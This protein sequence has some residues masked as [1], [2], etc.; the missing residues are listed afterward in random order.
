MT[1]IRTALNLTFNFKIQYSEFRIQNLS[2][3]MERLI[4]FVERFKEYFTF[5]ALVIVSLALIA[6][7]DLSKIG[8]F[9]TIVIG[10]VGWMQNVFS[11]IPN[12]GELRNE[13]RTL[14]EM[15]LQLSS[16]VVKMRHALLENKSLR[17][18]LS[19]NQKR[20]YE[21]ISSDVI[22]KNL[23][24]MRNYITLDKGTE[25][26]VQ[27]GMTVRN[28]FGL[29]GIVVGTVNKYTLVELIKNPDIKI[30]A[31]L[32]RNGI[33]GVVVWEGGENLV[34]KYVPKP[35][36][37]KVKDTIITTN[38]LNKYPPDIPIGEIIDIQEIAGDIFSKIIIKPFVNFHFIEQAFIIKYIPDID[39]NKLVREMDE[40][41]RIRKERTKPVKVK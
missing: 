21:Y 24:E 26:G 37:V 28:Y 30:S 35:F 17:E 31:R 19:L 3:S 39:R 15:N 13:N 22:G 18:S 20:E 34:M 10:S 1:V 27:I 41:L 7:G 16:E 2:Q 23:L 40:K 12:A 5:I 25:S 11:W 4:E 8:G 14:R 38:Y 9:R 32:L 29:I 6:M 33:D 36:D